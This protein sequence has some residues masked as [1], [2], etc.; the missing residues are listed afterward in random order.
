MQEMGYG[1]EEGRKKG[2]EEREDWGW[3][4]EEHGTWT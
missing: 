3:L 1:E 4:G 2:E